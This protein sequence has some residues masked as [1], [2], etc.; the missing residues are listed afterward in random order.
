MEGRGYQTRT[1]ITDPSN[2]I[3]VQNQGYAQLIQTIDPVPIHH[4]GLASTPPDSTESA[5]NYILDTNNPQSEL[6]M[7]YER[8]NREIAPKNSS[9][10][11]PVT[12]IHPPTQP[13]IAK[14]VTTPGYPSYSYVQERSAPSSS[15]YS[16]PHQTPKIGPPPTSV[17]PP[18]SHSH[19]PA[20]SRHPKPK[21]YPEIDPQARYSLDTF[22]PAKPWEFE[23]FNA[24]KWSKTFKNYSSQMKTR[25]DIPSMCCKVMR[26]HVML[27]TVTACTRGYYPGAGGAIFTRLLEETLAESSIAMNGEEVKE[28]ACHM[29]PPVYA[30]PEEHVFVVNGDAL[31][32]G[33]EALKANL[34]TCVLSLGNATVRGGGWKSGAGAQEESLFRRT[35]LYRRLCDPAEVRDLEAILVDPNLNVQQWTHSRAYLPI[36]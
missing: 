17:G 35:N 26:I 19:A 4:N 22:S 6:N 16:Q 9:I 24:S 8:A 11:A 33:L 3:E 29:K 36:S 27:D 34:K 25:F 32:V 2:P 14:Q 28:N 20:T 18:P 7:A 23:D 1:E 15:D 21:R 13:P 30:H 10:A 12:I 31:D 5:Y